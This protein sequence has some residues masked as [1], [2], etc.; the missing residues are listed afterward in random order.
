MIAGAVG[1]AI[2]LAWMAMSG[3]RGGDNRPPP[4]P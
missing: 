2:G 4:P 3:N 1:L